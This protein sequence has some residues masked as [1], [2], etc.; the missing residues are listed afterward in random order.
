[1]IKQLP[2]NL[3]GLMFRTAILL[4]ILGLNKTALVAEE[5]GV[6]SLKYEEPRVLSGTIYSADR[7]KPLFKFT[8]RCARSG[9]TLDVLREY[10]YLDGTVAMRERV[11]YRGDDLAEYELDDLQTGARGT[12]K[13]SSAPRDS[14]KKIVS[15]EYLKNTSSRGKPKKSSESLRRDAVISDMVA[16]FLKDH[17]AALLKGEEVKCRYLVVERRETVGFTFVKE[18]E[19]RREGRNL[20]IVKMSPTS[21]IISALVDPILFTIEKDGQRRVLEY[22]GRTPLKIK[23]GNKWKDL[24]GVTVFDW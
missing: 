6:K 16:A 23:E 5:P 19:L 4:V 11:V 12:A 24:D 20:V 8:R 14:G 2:H 13:I 3:A 21:A 10:T 17:W 7:K 9:S 22:A 1:M 15:Y 18:S